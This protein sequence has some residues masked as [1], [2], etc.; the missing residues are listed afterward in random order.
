MIGPLFASLVGSYKKIKISLLIV[1]FG[2]I[3]V[4]SHAKANM[5]FPHSEEVTCG[6][7]ALRFQAA[8]R[9]KMIR[10]GLIKTDSEVCISTLFYVLAWFSQFF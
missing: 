3:Q 9:L 8:I 10:T 2:L 6:G 1:F 4:R 7:N 5:R